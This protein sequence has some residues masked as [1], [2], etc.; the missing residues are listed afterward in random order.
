MLYRLAP[1]QWAPIP[2]GDARMRI[3]GDIRRG[4]IY[5]GVGEKPVYGG[6][7][8]VQ[9]YCGYTWI[10]TARHVVEEI[11]DGPF[12]IWGNFKTPEH[13][14]GAHWEPHPD[15][16]VDIAVAAFASKA[17]PHLP[18]DAILTKKAYPFYDVGVGDFAYVIGLFKRLPGEGRCSPVCHT[19][20][21]ALLPEDGETIPVNTGFGRTL[22]V[23]G[24]L[25]QV[26]TLPGLSGAPAFVRRTL[27]AEERADGVRPAVGGDVKLLGVWISSWREEA[28]SEHELPT[29]SIVP[30]GM[31]TV[32]PVERMTE[33]MDIFLANHA[34]GV[35]E[36]ASQADSA[37]PTKADN[38][39]HKED[40]NSLLTSVATAKKSGDQT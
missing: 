31:G 3:C 30:V 10:V 39:S 34:D 1:E 15:P 17:V 32:I 18:E 23:S 29:G 7:G 40:F 19:G 28:A 6:T 35:R 8:F 14:D 20:H 4:I 22:N 12:W 9:E 37:L 26:P 13:I 5:F 36:D 16:D 27:F 25:V 11:D 38:P 24:Y 2:G 21:I 33:V